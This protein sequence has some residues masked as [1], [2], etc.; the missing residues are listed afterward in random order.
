VIYAEKMSNH[1]INKHKYGIIIE[2]I[3]KIKF[4][5]NLY[6]FMLYKAK[7]SY[8]LYIAVKIKIFKIYN[9]IPSK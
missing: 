3:K 5:I 7:N 6:I 8:Q 4:F 1:P 2:N 9:I